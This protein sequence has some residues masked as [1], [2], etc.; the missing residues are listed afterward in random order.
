VVTSVERVLAHLQDAGYKITNARRTVVTVLCESNG[1]LTSAEVLDRVEARD[2]AI[3][4]AS[5]F[6]TL[7]L[8]TDLAIVRPTY[9]EPRT[10]NYVVMPTDGHH[11]HIICT[12]CSKVIELDEC[13]VSDLLE[14]IARLH[15][16]RLTGHLLELYGS[17]ADCN[18]SSG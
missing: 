18:A 8:L 16:L 5:V 17:C 6:R 14:D 4:R 13:H 3:G 15:N 2:P 7:D 12:T 1:H 10:P 11:A 9:L